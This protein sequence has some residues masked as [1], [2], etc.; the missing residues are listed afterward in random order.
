MLCKH[1]FAVFQSGLA[2]FGDLT[3]L[4]KDH[5]YM[6]LYTQLSLGEIQHF[7]RKNTH[8]DF[9][10]DDNTGSEK[11]VDL[12]KGESSESSIESSYC[13]LSL[14]RSAIN[15]KKINTKG[16]LKQLIDLHYK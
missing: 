10:N 1:F 12:D 5:P 11:I 6:R 4:F 16:L 13:E 15:I 8:A 3:E 7:V 9:S 14:K 2:K